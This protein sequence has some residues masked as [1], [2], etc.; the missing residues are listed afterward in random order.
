MIRGRYQTA[1]IWKTMIRNRVP[2]VPTVLL[3]TGE[4]RH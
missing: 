4:E 1:E 2:T 3:L